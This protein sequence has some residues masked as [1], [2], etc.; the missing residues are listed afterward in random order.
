MSRDELLE[1]FFDL[2]GGAGSQYPVLYSYYLRSGKM[3]PHHHLSAKGRV[4]CSE[5][6]SAL[7]NRWRLVRGTPEQLA[8]A[9]LTGLTGLRR[10]AGTVE[11]LCPAEQAARFP[12]GTVSPPGWRTSWCIW[13][14]R[15]GHEG[16]A[17]QGSLPCRCFR[18]PTASG[19]WQGCCSFRIILILSPF[20]TPR[21]VMFLF[22]Y[23]RENRDLNYM[24]TLPITKGQMVKARVVQTAAIE[25]GML[26][27]CLPFMAVRGA[28]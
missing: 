6:Q 11:G 22:Q 2:G 1:L 25:M 12:A 10:H 27:A 23:N 5:E 19:C 20:S 24:M 14:G 3:R 8:G 15:R 28:L 17:A 26:V 16:V 4:L 13:N 18:C 21:G 7:L 9:E